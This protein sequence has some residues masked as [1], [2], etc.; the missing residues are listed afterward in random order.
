MKA[1]IFEKYGS[2]KDVL[3]LK[4]IEKPTPKPDEVL[5][6]VRAAA[7]NALDW[8]LTCADPFLVRLGE[9][10]FKPKNSLTGVDFA[11]DIEAVGSAVTDFKPGDAVFGLAST[12]AFAEYVCV[13]P[14]EIVHKPQNATYEE[15][16]AMGVAGLTALQGLRDAGE[17]QPGK[18]VLIN[19]ASGGVGTFAVQIAKAFGA[20]V[21]AVCSTGKVEQSRSIGADHVI[22]YKKTDFIKNGQQ[23]DLI[24]DVAA[25]YSMRQISRALTPQ[26]IYAIAGF[27][28]MGHLIFQVLL[29]GKL[30]SRKNG[31]Q[32]RLMQTAHSTP[33]DMLKLKELL[34]SGQVKPVI[35]KTYPLA[36]TAKAIQYLY[37]G[38]AHGKIVI[39]I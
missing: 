14:K 19:G 23:Y 28:G 32:F 29:M 4:E 18:K 25:N 15:A 21:T 16:A 30:M 17:I 27:S 2:P 22:D 26:G 35:E 1:I 5:V 10:F 11:G 3:Q 13:K 33:E 12:G 36:E 38:H 7:T 8:H 20:E 34:E 9:G 37:E 31:K 39:T 24:Y 6:K